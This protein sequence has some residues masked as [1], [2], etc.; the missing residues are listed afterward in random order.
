MRWRRVGCRLLIRKM[1]NGGLEP[2][3]PEELFLSGSALQGRGMGSLPEGVLE[4]ERPKG[5]PRTG[6]A[7]FSRR[8]GKGG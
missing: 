3:E 1:M 4:E 8:A 6:A 5:E 2:D 7:S